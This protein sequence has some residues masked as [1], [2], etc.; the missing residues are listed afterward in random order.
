MDVPGKMIL[1]QVSYRPGA[2]RFFQGLLVGPK[3]GAQSS[4]LSLPILEMCMGLSVLK[5]NI[6]TC[7]HARVPGRRYRVQRTTYSPLLL[8]CSLWGL[9]SGPQSCRQC[10]LSSELSHQPGSSVLTELS[11]SMEQP[12]GS[13]SFWLS[14][15]FQSQGSRPNQCC[16]WGE[17]GSDIFSDTKAWNRRVRNS[18]NMSWR[19][20]ACLLLHQV[21]GGETQSTF[22]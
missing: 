6:L 9:N 3:R 1:G 21:D 15:R 2:R 18:F 7:V 4:N 8:S 22:L 13:V 12:G 16:V 10:H 19:R 11:Q 5:I 20:R 14:A 17:L